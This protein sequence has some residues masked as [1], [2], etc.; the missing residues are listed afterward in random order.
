MS[1]GKVL[2]FFPA[3]GVLLACLAGAP[4]TAAQT[5]A[6]AEGVRATARQQVEVRQGTQK[7]V[8]QSAEKK[9]LLSDRLERLRTE[10]KAV[11]RQREKTDSYVLDMR[12]RVAE[13]QR[14]VKE[15]ERLS[16]E[17]EPFLDATS[18]E[19]RGFVDQDLPFLSAER[20]KRLDALDQTLNR[21]GAPVT[22]KLRTLLTALEIEARYGSTVGS[23]EVE[24]D[25]A[26]SQKLMRVFRLG[27]LALF[28]LSPDESQAWRFDRQS[29]RFLPMEQYLA[30]LGRAADIAERKRVVELV[31]LP[32][33]RPVADGGSGEPKP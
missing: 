8:D 21:Y 33:G 14:R 10:L 11:R 23:R 7:L 9:H 3:A 4:A 12:A 26:G 31:E 17:M 27:R 25:L 15:L 6:D 22:T 2:L 5:A 29:G 16:Q 13:L 1:Y 30:D 32:V 20:Q 18:R 28:A 24:V 19:L